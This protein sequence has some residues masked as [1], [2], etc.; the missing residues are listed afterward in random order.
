MNIFFQSYFKRFQELYLELEEAVKDLPPEALDWQPGPEM[1]SM[2]ILVVHTVG[3][4]RYWLGEVILSE[5]PQRDR[6]AE[7]RTKGLNATDLRQQLHD[8]LAYIETAL[9]KLTVEHLAEERYA[10][11]HEEKYTVA[12]VLSHA[13]AHTATHVGHLQIGRQLWE[14]R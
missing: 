13:I 3:S 9:G 6:P 4:N 1:N 5:T 7:F 14:M 8:S 10:P 2:N 11:S 12:W